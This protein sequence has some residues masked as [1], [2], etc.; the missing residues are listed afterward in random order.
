MA[1]LQQF[2]EEGL[3][4]MT[5]KPFQQSNRREPPPVIIP[6][7]GVPIPA[8]PPAERRRLEESEDEAK[9]ARSS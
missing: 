2:I 7:R 6:P 8:T 3:R 9:H 1:N 4:G 5:E